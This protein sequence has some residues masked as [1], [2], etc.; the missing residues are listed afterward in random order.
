[1]DVTTYVNIVLV[2]IGFIT[3]YYNKRQT[4]IN[5]APRIVVK[6]TNFNK[7][8]DKPSVISCK[9]TNAGNGVALQTYLL[10]RIKDYYDYN[11]E[12]HLSKPEN[13]IYPREESDRNIEILI[14]NA[15]DID[16][17]DIYIISL[18]FFENIHVSKLEFSRNNE[19]LT[20]LMKPVKVISK[21]N[22]KYSTY[23]DWI[24]Q[25]V[26]Q[27]NTYAH[28]HERNKRKILEDLENR[29]GK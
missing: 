21:L 14:E 22:P 24:N 29:L 12:A 11:I 16:K 25:A 28:Q 10:V 1:M 6:K 3:L 9:V 13:L 15:L 5:D 20:K 26:E 8:K 2:L 23:N 17:A 7:N 27:E 4:I 19:H 18:D